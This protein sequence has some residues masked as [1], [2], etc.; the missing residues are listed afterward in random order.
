MNCIY[1]AYHVTANDCIAS[2]IIFCQAFLSLMLYLR[3]LGI[4]HWEAWQEPGAEHCSTAQAARLSHRHCTPSP[5]P[6][7]R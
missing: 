2:H 5:R 3:P 4:T 1:E 6:E 7:L